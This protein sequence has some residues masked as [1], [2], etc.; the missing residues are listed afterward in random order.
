LKNTTPEE[1]ATY[2]ED[3]QKAFAV[4]QKLVLICSLMEIIIIIV[5]VA[6][7]YVFTE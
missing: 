4:Q 5:I 6:V 3:Q 1:L 2:T 7:I